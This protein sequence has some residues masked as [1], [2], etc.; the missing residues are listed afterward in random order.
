MRRGFNCDSD[1]DRASPPRHTA[2]R[3]TVRFGGTAVR[4]ATVVVAITFLVN[5]G[6]STMNNTEK[7]V[8]IGGALGAGLGTAIGA[9]TGNPKTG[10]VAGGLVGAGLGGLIGNEEDKK[11]AARAEARDVAA[12]SSAAAANPPLG[13]IDVV[14]LTQEGVDPEVI[15]TQIQQTGS[16][17]QLTTTDIS[18]L[19]ENRVNPRVI[20]AMQSARTTPL[21]VQQQPRTV[22]VRQPRTVIV[23]EPV[24]VPQPVI[25]PAAGF[26]YHRRW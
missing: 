26:H 16:T 4:N 12:A 20:R 17:F 25:V 14:K 21:A 8:G 15:V 18:Y 5:A 6:C 10:A 11:D 2:P 22:V 9:A 7:G 3:G 13:M 1:L 23:E 24:F 19:T